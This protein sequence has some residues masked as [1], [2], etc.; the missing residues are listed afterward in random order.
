MARYQDAIDWIAANDDNEW[1]GD[2]NSKEWDGEGPA[3]APNMSVTTCLIADL[4]NK[5]H[6]EVVADLKKALRRE[7]NR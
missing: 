4:W 3:D 2:F 7:R 1:I 5:T 6:L